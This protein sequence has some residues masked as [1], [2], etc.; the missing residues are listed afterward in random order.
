MSQRI[1]EMKYEVVL[2]ILYNN[3]HRHAPVNVNKQEKKR[4]GQGLKVAF[5]LENEKGVLQKR[6]TMLQNYSDF[7]LIKVEL[8]NMNLRGNLLLEHLEQNT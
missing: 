8:T 3:H 2:S 5:Q 6:L 1:R 4:T 7:K